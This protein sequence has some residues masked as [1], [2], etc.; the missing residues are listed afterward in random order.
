MLERADVGHHD[1]GGCVRPGVRVVMESRR[2]IYVLYD[3][4]IIE[5]IASTLILKVSGSR[6]KNPFMLA[7]PLARSQLD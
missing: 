3:L 2:Q 4:V 5:C 1:V 7:A 6:V